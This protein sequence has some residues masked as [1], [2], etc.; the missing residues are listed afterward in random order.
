MAKKIEI[1][2][3]K[4]GAYREV[5]FHLDPSQ[6]PAAVRDAMMKMH[7]NAYRRR[8]RDGRRHRSLRADQHVGRRVRD[9]VLPTARSTSEENQVPAD[10]VP[11]K[12]GVMGCLAAPS[13]P[14]RRSATTSASW[15]SGTSSWF[16]RATT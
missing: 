6:V 14:T 5:E 16:A 7:P 9:H 3:D 13:T 4:N 2:V 8:G 12:D 11:V 15:S 1:Q 10:K